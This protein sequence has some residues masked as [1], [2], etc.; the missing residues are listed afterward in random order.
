MR[1]RTQRAI[2]VG[3]VGLGR[4]KTFMKQAELAGMK[5]VALCDT[6]EEKL[7]PMAKEFG[8]TAYTDYDRFLEHDLDAV[9]LANYCHEHA[10]FAVKALDAGRHVL[11]ETLACK[12]LGE[13]VALARAVERS[14]K[15][16]CFSE[17]YCYMAYIQEM[18]RLYRAGEIGAMQAAECE[19]MHPMSMRDKL[20]ITPGLNHWRAHRPSTYYPTH[21]LGPIMFIADT[22]PVSV[23]ARSIPEHPEDKHHSP[24]RVGDCSAVIVCRM[25][26]GSLVTVNGLGL[27]GHGNWYRIHGT[28][29]LMENLRVR[30]EQHKLRV[31]HDP[32]D[33]KRGQPEEVIYRPRFPHH[34]AEAL[35]AGHG[36]GDFYTVWHFAEAIRKGRQPYLDVYRGVSMSIVAMQGWRSCLADGAPVEVPDF[37]KE[38]VRSRHE[39]DQWSPF[40]EDAGPGQPPP[41]I[42]GFNT[43]SARAVRKA[44][45]IWAERVDPGG[46]PGGRHPGVGCRTGHARA[47][48]R[49]DPVWMVRRLTA[50][51]QQGRDVGRHHVWDKGHEI[52]AVF[53]VFQ[54][55]PVNAIGPEDVDGQPHDGRR[56]VAGRL[57]RRPCAP[58]G[59]GAAAHALDVQMEIPAR[60]QT[61]VALS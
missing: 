14:G 27:R 1:K 60:L 15:I 57:G 56:Q 24:V 38:S 12:T 11:S 10:P 23:I 3:V 7:I 36:G 45:T 8:V 32:F 47:A 25:D 6:W 53:S 48:G 17:N 33:C 30:G 50:S 31:Y 21:A 43:P 52:L 5:L 18:R 46:W 42:C 40:P 44:R 20:S 55:H 13:G 41:S 39:H 4:G 9:V 19:Y 29:G 54:L 61:P 37:R 2:K 58:V 51:T 16:Y 34:E 59:Q 26:D 28:R 22:R 35:K 49:R